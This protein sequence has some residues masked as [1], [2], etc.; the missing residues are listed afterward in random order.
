MIRY[1]VDLDGFVAKGYGFIAKEIAILDVRANGLTRNYYFKVGSLKDYNFNKDQ[2][3]SIHYVTR[4]IHGLK[5]RDFYKHTTF[6]DD[7]KTFPPDKS[8][9]S[10]DSLEPL[11]KLMVRKCNINDDDKIAYKGG[12][13]EQNVLNSIGFGRLGFN[14]ERIGCPKFEELYKRYN[15]S[16]TVESCRWHMKVISLKKSSTSATSINIPHCSK[17]EVYYFYLW[18][19]DYN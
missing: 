9:L 6:I 14:L 10:Q 11:F 7:D 16:S 5:F 13:Y 1:I 4:H 2:L 15:S 12:I 3:R 18:Y 17:V 8:E 19:I